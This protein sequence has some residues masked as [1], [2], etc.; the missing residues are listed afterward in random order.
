MAA[1]G[2]GDERDMR[3]AAAAGGVLVWERANGDLGRDG[4][5]RRYRTRRRDETELV[6]RG[7]AGHVFSVAVFSWRFYLII[8]YTYIVSSFLLPFHLITYISPY[9]HSIHLIHLKDFP[10]PPPAC[11]P[12]SAGLG[13]VPPPPGVGG[14]GVDDACVAGV[15]G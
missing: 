12:L 5:T 13:L 1:D 9:H 2:G 14:A 8:D 10:R 3:G 6:L 4:G 11:S 15:D 7:A